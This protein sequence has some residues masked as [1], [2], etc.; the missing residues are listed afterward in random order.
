MA[1]N[2]RVVPPFRSLNP[3]LVE[4][5]VVDRVVLV[6]PDPFRH[7]VHA[8]LGEERQ[9]RRVERGLPVDL[10]PQRDR[11]G[12]IGDL[13]VDGVGNFRVEASVAV[14]AGVQVVRVIEGPRRADCESN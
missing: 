2:E 11:R 12:R 5:D 3:E 9:P 10:R 6:V 7:E 14:Q 8:A 4:Q 13:R 1:R